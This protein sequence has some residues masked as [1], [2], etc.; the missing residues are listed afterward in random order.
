MA[1]AS[2]DEGIQYDGRRVVDLSPAEEDWADDAPGQGCSVASGSFCS[3]RGG[4][5]G[6]LADLQQSVRNGHRWCSFGSGPR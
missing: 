6:R 2:D 5:G 4:Y 1:Q 3:C